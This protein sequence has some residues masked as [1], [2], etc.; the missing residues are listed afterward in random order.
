[1]QNLYMKESGGSSANSITSLVDG[2]LWENPVG[3][4]ALQMSKS[5]SLNMGVVHQ[6]CQ[7][8][9]TTQFQ[10]QDQNSSST[11]SSGQ[12][13]PEVASAGGSDTYG[14]STSLPQSGPDIISCTF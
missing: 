4:D 6:N 10:V 12:S 14:Q 9:K 8:S 1:M 3:P 7:H 2:R 5:L 11:Q 13:Y